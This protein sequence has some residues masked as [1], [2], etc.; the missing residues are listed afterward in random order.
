MCINPVR[1]QTAKSRRNDAKFVNV[2]C[3]KCPECVKAKQNAWLFRFNQQLLVSP[4]ALFVTLT[5]N[6]ESL[7]YANLWYNEDG[8]A[9]LHNMTLR[10]R[11][12]QLFFKNLRYEYSKLSKKRIKYMLVGEYGSKFGRPHYHAIIFNLDYPHLIDSEW[13]HG[14]VYRPVL[15]T[16]RGGMSYVLK[17]ISK[18]RNVNNYGIPEFSLTSKG[19]GENYIT[20]E[21]LKWHTSNVENTYVRSDGFKLTM[22]RYYK[23]KMFDTE[24]YASVTSYLQKRAENK[25]TEQLKAL[26]KKYPRKSEEFLL[27]RLE[28]SNLNRR[29]DRRKDTF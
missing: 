1:L 22:P 7:P 2:P 25:E 20:A 14:F 19:L 13:I 12:V 16:S 15:D 9:D 23:R 3:G 8:T 6:D 28:L 24:Q 5:Y 21:S 10:K 17:Y 27:K 29:F 26:R 4:L 11:D 18:N